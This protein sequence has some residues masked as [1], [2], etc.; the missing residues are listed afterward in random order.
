M[1]CESG[2][3]NK[4]VLYLSLY[5][6]QNREVYYNLLQEVREQG[7]WETWLEFF[8]EGVITSSKQAMQTAT[9]INNLF[10]T[11][12]DK[13]ASL[14]RARFGC[15]KVHDFLKQLPQ[16]S[17]SLLARKLEIT[18]PTARAAVNHLLTLGILEEVS[19]KQRDKEY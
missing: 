14:G 1:L 6:K 10:R 13:I 7:T 11:D 17:V 8:L 5:L 18:A 4:P 12:I 2:M 19:S 16:V 3:L 15:E 9:D